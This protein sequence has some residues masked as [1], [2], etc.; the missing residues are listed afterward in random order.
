MSWGNRSTPPLQSEQ[1]MLVRVALTETAPCR[2][3]VGA[4]C[5]TVS[6]GECTAL[7]PFFRPVAVPSAGLKPE[8]FL[9]LGL[10]G[11]L[12]FPTH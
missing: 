4:S 2:A 5:A 3:T 12:S 6:T 10:D 9:K 7:T 8:D 11:L 1:V